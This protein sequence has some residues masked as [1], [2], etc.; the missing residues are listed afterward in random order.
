MTTL[1]ERQRRR[2]SADILNA[3][4]AL[5]GEKGF[6]E[7][8][9]EEIAERSEVGVATVY[10]YFGTKSDLLHSLLQRYI[11]SEAALGESVLEHPPATM[12]DGMTELFSVYLDGMV[13]RCGPRLTNEFLAMALSKQFKYGQDTYALKMRFLVQCRDLVSH[14]RQAGQL[15]DN[16]TDDEAAATCYGA[17]VMPLALFAIG[18]GID[19]PMTKAMMHRNLQLVFTGIGSSANASADDE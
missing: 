7:T 8:S 15:R 10:N 9:V 18:A 19:A 11:E 6:E 12:I 17:V 3:A 2:R 4:E 16:I 14:Y 13:S 1:R 5:I